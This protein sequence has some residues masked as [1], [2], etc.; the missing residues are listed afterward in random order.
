MGWIKCVRCGNW[1]DKD[2][3]YHSGDV[4]LIQIFRKCYGYG[5]HLHYYC[6]CGTQALYPSAHKTYVLQVTAGAKFP[7]VILC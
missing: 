7:R 6:S 5:E 2:V 3:K 1:M 4:S